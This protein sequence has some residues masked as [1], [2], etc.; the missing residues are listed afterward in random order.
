MRS[1]A[2]FLLVLALQACATHPP[3]ARDCPPLPTLPV[4]P[5]AAQRDRHTEAIVGQYLRCAGVTP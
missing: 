5:T 3:V 4:N 2:A 1:A